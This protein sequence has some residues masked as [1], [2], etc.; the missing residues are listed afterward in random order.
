VIR[1]RGALLLLLAAAFSARAEPRIQWVP[2]AERTCVEVSGLDDAALVA[3]RD[4]PVEKW[5]ELLAVRVK[6]DGA[7]A[8]LGK[9]Q[10]DARTV[11]FTPQFPLTPG[12]AYRAEFDTIR[13]PGAAADARRVTSEFTVPTPP[14]GAATVVTHVFPSADEVPE[15][16]LKFYL[17]FSAP[18]SRGHI[19]DHIH[20]RNEAGKDVELPF[21]EIDEEL[22]DPEMKRLTL[23]IDPGRIKRG[24]RPLEEIG[25]ALEQGRRFTLA[26][27]AAWLDATGQ[28]L[29]QKH[30]RTFR[31]GPP[32]RAPIEPSEWKITAPSA[33]STDAL[34]IAFPKPMDHALALRL[35]RVTRAAGTP[36]EGTTALADAER[37]W[38][39]TP[40]RPWLPGPHQ[41]IVTTTLEDLAGNNIGKAFEVDLRER[42]EL[43]DLAKSVK[44]PFEVK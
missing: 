32:D 27:D 36:V 22:W 26:I 43:L 3:V 30:E 23:F 37:R 17:H 18:M 8:M 1:G 38:T 20:L 25:P 7:P 24:V 19:Y 34:R 4:W 6:Q 16:L 9:W 15:N 31:V 10:A 33:G 5:R 14:R 11:R 28:P 35:L 39:F 13:L 40:A 42:G 44:L 2:A 41:L 29:A 21:L 12:V